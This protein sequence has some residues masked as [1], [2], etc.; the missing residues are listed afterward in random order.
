MKRIL[1]IDDE[2]NLLQ[3][4]KLILTKHGFDVHT[5][6]TIEKAKELLNNTFDFIL[7]DYYMGTEN[8]S[9]FIKEMIEKIE[10]KKIC[11]LSGTQ[12]KE[13]IKKLN[14]IGVVNFLKKPIEYDKIIEMVNNNS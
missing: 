8:T 1:L 10:V 5:A 7:V 2:V 9:N 4:F 6:N 14:K 11:V 3:I 12:R 13:D